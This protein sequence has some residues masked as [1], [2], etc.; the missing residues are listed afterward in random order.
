M[1][2]SVI[3][4]SP[5]RDALI[6][7]IPL[8][9]QTSSTGG[10]MHSLLPVTSI[11]FHSDHACDLEITQG[12]TQALLIKDV[13]MQGGQIRAGGVVTGTGNVMVQSYLDKAPSMQGYLIPRGIDVWGMDLSLGQ[14]EPRGRAQIY[15]IRNEA[16]IVNMTDRARLVRKLYCGP[17]EGADGGYVCDLT[18][19]PCLNPP[20]SG[21]IVGC[22]T[23]PHMS[24]ILITEQYGYT[25]SEDGEKFTA[26][27]HDMVEL[28][29]TPDKTDYLITKVKIAVPRNVMIDNHMR[30]SKGGEIAVKAVDDEREAIVEA[31]IG[32]KNGRIPESALDLLI[33]KYL[34]K[35]AQ[36]NAPLP[37]IPS[38]T[39]R[40]MSTALAI[41]QGKLDTM[42]N[43]TRGVSGY[44]ATLNSPDVFMKRYIERG[45]PTGLTPEEEQEERAKQDAERAEIENYNATVVVPKIE[46]YMNAVRKTVLN[47]MY[48][49]TFVRTRLLY[50]KFIETGSL[51]TRADRDS[52]TVQSYELMPV[53]TNEFDVV[54]PYHVVY[55]AQPTEAIPLGILMTSSDDQ[56]QE[57]PPSMSM[58]FNISSVVQ[59]EY[60]DVTTVLGQN[61]PKVAAGVL[62][63]KREIEEGNAARG[64]ITVESVKLL[65]QNVLHVCEKMATAIASMRGR[66]PVEGVASVKVNNEFV[67]FTDNVTIYND[68]WVSQKGDV[69]VVDRSKREKLPNTCHMFRIFCFLGEDST[70]KFYMRPMVLVYIKD[71][72]I[73]CYKNQMATTALLY[74]YLEKK[75][76]TSEIF[77]RIWSHGGAVESGVI[78]RGE[79][80]LTTLLPHLRKLPTM[81]Q[82]VDKI[83]IG[84]SM[85]GMRLVDK[86]KTKGERNLLTVNY[87]DAYDPGTNPQYPLIE[88]T[89]SIRATEISVVDHFRDQ[90]GTM[91]D[92][93]TDN[94]TVYVRFTPPHVT[95]RAWGAF[96]KSEFL[97]AIAHLKVKSPLT[98]QMM[99]SHPRLREDV[100]IYTHA[101]PNGSKRIF[102]PLPAVTSRFGSQFEWMHQMD[103][104]LTATPLAV[105]KLG[106]SLFALNGL[107]YQVRNKRRIIAQ[108]APTMQVGSVLT[109]FP[110][111][112]TR[113]RWGVNITHE[114]ESADE[115]DEKMEDKLTKLFGNYVVLLYGTA[116]QVKKGTFIYPINKFFNQ[117]GNE[118]VEIL[119][120]LSDEEHLANSHIQAD[121]NREFP[122]VKNKAGKSLS[123]IR[124]EM[125]GLVANRLSEVLPGVYPSAE[126]VQTSDVL[127]LT[128]VYSAYHPLVEHAELLLVEYLAL[129]NRPPTEIN[130]EVVQ[131][132]KM[133]IEKVIYI[134]RYQTALYAKMNTLT[135]QTITPLLHTPPFITQTD[136]N[137]VSIE[138]LDNPIRFTSNQRT[139]FVA[140]VQW[141]TKSLE[142]IGDVTLKGYGYLGDVRSKISGAIRKLQR[143]LNDVRA[144]QDN[145]A[146]KGEFDP[147]DMD[148]LERDAESVMNEIRP[149]YELYSSLYVLD[150]ALEIPEEAQPDLSVDGW[151]YDLKEFP[152]SYLYGLSFR[153]K[154]ADVTEFVPEN[155]LF[156]D[157]SMNLERDSAFSNMSSQI[158]LFMTVV[159]GD[160]SANG[161]VQTELPSSDGWL[162]VNGI[163]QRV[164]KRST[165]I[166]LFYMMDAHPSAGDNQRMLPDY[167]LV[168]MAIQLPRVGLE[169]EMA[170]QPGNVNI[171]RTYDRML[172]Y[173]NNPYNGMIPGARLGTSDNRKILMRDM[174]SSERAFRFTRTDNMLA[175]SMLRPSPAAPAPQSI[176]DI[177][178]L[179]SIGYFALEDATYHHTVPYISMAPAHYMPVT[180]AFGTE[181][182][183]GADFTF[184]TNDITKAFRALA[185][186][187]YKR[188]STDPPRQR[189]GDVLYPDFVDYWKGKRSLLMYDK[190][191]VET[192]HPDIFRMIGD[193]TLSQNGTFMMMRDEETY[194]PITTNIM[195][196]MDVSA[197][198]N[199]TVASSATSATSRS[200]L[201]TMGVSADMQSGTQVAR[202]SGNIA[203]T[204]YVKGVQIE[205]TLIGNM[206]CVGRMVYPQQ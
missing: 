47:H 28:T 46:G 202:A 2:A 168:G 180:V 191:L 122:G 140:L 128:E 50:S 111:I 108:A 148:K 52:I 164:F 196:Q 25:R 159:N 98:I 72:Y 125:I 16:S 78:H 130:M 200:G 141:A 45:I 35:T 26:K 75:M 149:V 13:F 120:R 192:G 87:V 14:N 172:L 105:M 121:V 59:N 57:R 139:N 22:L 19:N 113:A 136:V 38:P 143:R 116:A 27:V 152:M 4:S 1:E 145:L 68:F 30:L 147:E 193:P 34:N 146:R 181:R 70:P 3:I 119:K 171:V 161:S 144:M 24:T 176:P 186:Q 21:R 76:G 158:P 101:T 7:R 10:N 11:Q 49:A 165:K 179:V 85:I 167:Y 107:A 135:S 109:N 62:P 204:Y 183:S 133:F 157:G 137:K 163:Q 6:T 37:T 91:R 174:F 83:N 138:P 189:I 43:N 51:R 39:A 96:N 127:T 80:H 190:E 82:T 206:V 175:Y 79:N 94:S 123:Q 199:Q 151:D 5:D 61:D 129:K 187:F 166:R 155:F 23:L 182:L 124:D 142:V 184:D 126:S 89:K 100:A 18:D 92:R 103:S 9:I 55:A 41:D 131:R 88:V 115:N 162:S 63:G 154:D 44:A 156:G 84:G 194:A 132:M 86:R 65:N 36:A 117:L 102:L 40:F 12:G 56:A 178:D 73:A 67:G 93:A 104:R 32:L 170:F 54:S 69:A 177:N 114:N 71:V 95:R 97:N 112:D 118:T 8:M 110:E 99:L 58:V 134:K 185:I 53:R 66:P 74:A 15:L 160:I 81:T 203:K 31:V 197:A 20:L 60:V 33:W 201:S 150:D 42:V 64:K 195:N 29:F 106:Q 153:Q 77:G 90:N 169:R 205:L 17:V 188:V 173:T 48:E 198:D